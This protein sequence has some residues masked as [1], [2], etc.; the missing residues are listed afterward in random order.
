MNMLV[1]GVAYTETKKIP[2]QEDFF[3]KKVKQKIPRIVTI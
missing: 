3:L 1:W 2:H